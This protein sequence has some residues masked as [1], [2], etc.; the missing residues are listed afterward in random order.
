MYDVK[1]GV[2][3]G[4]HR[5]RYAYRDNMTDVIVH[6]LTTDQKG[7]AR[8]RLEAF[9][10]SALTCS[11]SEMS[12]IGEEDRH[13]QNNACCKFTKERFCIGIDG[14][15][16]RSKHWIRFCSMKLRAMFHMI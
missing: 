7:K 2:V 4:I 16:Y 3:H 12:G 11:E 6:H 8:D 10:T 13:V 15:L 9:L 1:F 5:D 14:Y